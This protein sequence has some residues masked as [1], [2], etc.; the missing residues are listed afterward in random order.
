MCSIIITN[1]EEETAAYA[2][3]LASLLKAGDFIALNG[4]L[5]AGKTAFVRGLAQGLS[6]RERVVSPTFTLLR[7][8]DSGTLPLYHF[9]FYRVHSSNEL[10]DI[11][12]YDCAEQDGVCVCEWAELI[13]EA[14]PQNR[15][16][17]SI[18]QP[19]GQAEVRKLT[20]KEIGGFKRLKA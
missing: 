12:F 18:E 20:I 1:S 3:S 7:W 10:E 9:D 13:V 14:L 8:Y 11:G 19:E 17:I 5:G 2:K 4:C 15:L 16:E 6:V